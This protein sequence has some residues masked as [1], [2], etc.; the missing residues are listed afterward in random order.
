MAPPRSPAP[1]P[2]GGDANPPK[3]A[4]K[5][6]PEPPP[7][8]VIPPAERKIG[9]APGNLRDREEAFKRRRGGRA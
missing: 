9:E 4:P 3:A 1:R 5:A 8:T 7:A 6:P 2:P